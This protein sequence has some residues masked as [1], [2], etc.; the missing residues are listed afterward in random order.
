[1]QSTLTQEKGIRRG[2]GQ[3]PEDPLPGPAREVK[4]G[5]GHPKSDLSQPDR[6]LVT[7]HIE[8]TFPLSHP[9]LVD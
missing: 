3:H 1:M 8:R 4:I 5:L 9:N 6:R 7:S 2:Q